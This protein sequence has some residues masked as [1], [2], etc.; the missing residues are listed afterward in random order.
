MLNTGGRDGKSQEWQ[1]ET[2]GEILWDSLGESHQAAKKG[3]TLCWKAMLKASRREFR[4][5]GGIF[6]ALSFLVSKSHLQGL[7][8]F[9]AQH[10]QVRA[11]TR[12]SFCQLSRFQWPRNR[13]FQHLPGH[14]L[15]PPG[16]CPE[17]IRVRLPDSAQLLWPC[18]SL[19]RGIPIPCRWLLGCVWQY[20]LCSFAQKESNDDFNHRLI[21]P[22]YACSKGQLADLKLATDVHRLH[23]QPHQQ[24]YVVHMDTSFKQVCW[25]GREKLWRVLT[26]KRI[27]GDSC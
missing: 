2:E 26:E 15:A 21:D 10:G 3:S 12:G 4:N 13:R 19:P 7:L 11:A 6:L 24:K 5:V 14:W 20:A 9:A 18:G 27:G 23:F 16:H 22:G 17:P 1:V 8:C 25:Q